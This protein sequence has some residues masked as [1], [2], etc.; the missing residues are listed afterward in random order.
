MLVSSFTVLVLEWKREIGA[1]GRTWRGRKTRKKRLQAHGIFETA[2]TADQ[3]RGQND[4][5]SLGVL[6]FACEAGAYQSYCRPP[7]NEEDSSRC[8][9][10]QLYVAKGGKEKKLFPA[11]AVG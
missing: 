4:E 5:V 8:V 2:L 1:R 3:G 10:L 7:L 9:V 6:E 11:L